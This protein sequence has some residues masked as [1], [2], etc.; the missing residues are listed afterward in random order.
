MKHSSSSIPLSQRVFRANRFLSEHFDRLFSKRLKGW[1]CGKLQPQEYIKNGM[2]VADIGGGKKPFLKRDEM[3]S[4]GITYVGLDIDP[5]ELRA[6]PPGAYSHTKVIDLTSL[7]ESYRPNFD[8]IICMNTLEHVRDADAALGALIVMLKPGGRCYLQVPC[9]KALF[10]RLNRV[11]GEKFKRRLLHYVFPAK[12]G[13][14]FPAFYDKAT[15][16]D[17]CAIIKKRGAMVETVSVNYWSSYFSKIF[18]LYVIWRLL[19]ILQLVFSNDY[20]E[21]FGIIFSKPRGPHEQITPRR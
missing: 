19:S 18:P 12:S 20:C 17:Y 9:R 16:G 15:P 4:L 21:K 5:Q 2:T 14:G 11:L 6:A 3:Q 1:S 10:A 8:L 7:P 13:D